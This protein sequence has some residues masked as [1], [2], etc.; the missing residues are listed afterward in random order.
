MFEDLEYY[1]LVCEYRQLKDDE[2]RNES[3]ALRGRGYE[4]HWERTCPPQFGAWMYNIE[5]K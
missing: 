5:T 1:T 2:V 3:N 4:C